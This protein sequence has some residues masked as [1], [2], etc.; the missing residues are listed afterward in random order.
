MANLF[1]QCTA[2]HPVHRTHQTTSSSTASSSP[3]IHSSWTGSENA[4]TVSSYCC[5]EH[6]DSTL[7]PK[8][9]RF[10]RFSKIL[11]ALALLSET[12]RFL[13]FLQKPRANQP[14]AL[15]SYRIF[16]ML[17]ACKIPAS[18]M[19]VILPRLFAFCIPHLCLK[20]TKESE[21]MGQTWHPCPNDK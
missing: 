4:Y 16:A 1:L 12:L 6:T 18:F 9:L 13:R 5:Q 7:S 2:D 21:R 11:A 8:S 14:A 20:R 15:L 3:F 19:P 10:H 17:F